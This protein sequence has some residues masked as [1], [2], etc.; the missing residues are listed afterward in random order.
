MLK[1]PALSGSGK[2][3]YP[4]LRMH[5]AKARLAA[6]AELAGDGLADPLQAAANVA[7][8]ATTATMQPSRRRRL[9][10]RWLLAPSFITSLAF[11]VT[12]RCAPQGA[13]S[14]HGRVPPPGG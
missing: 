12:V 3:G 6:C 11:H 4:W 2:R 13:F 7:R 5:W 1:F 14:R 10:R 9:P 8:Q